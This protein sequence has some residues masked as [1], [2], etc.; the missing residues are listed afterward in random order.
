MVREVRDTLYDLRTDVSDERTVEDV[1]TEFGSRVERRSDMKVVLRVDQTARMPQLQERELW[2]IAQE[3]IV[4]AE[5][6][7]GGTRIDVFWY[8]DGLEAVAEVRDDGAGMPLGR[9]GRLDS[10]G[11]LGM[12]ERAAS[13]GA[14]L[15]VESIPRRGV[16]V[17]V[18]L[19][20]EH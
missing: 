6:H 2:R 15:S 13:I 14:N 7:S 4:N 17:R 9:V 19:R 11:M 18:T 8:S 1:L 20:N 3:A 12:R 10:Y 16:T 5:R